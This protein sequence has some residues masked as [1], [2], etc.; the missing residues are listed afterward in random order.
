MLPASH[1]PSRTA[2]PLPTLAG[3][4]PWLAPLRA[5]VLK[6]RKTAHI[7]QEQ[8]FQ[9]IAEALDRRAQR[10]PLDRDDV[11][12]HLKARLGLRPHQPEL[13]HLRPPACLVG[14]DTKKVAYL[15]AKSGFLDDLASR[16]G[17]GPFISSELA[18][19]QHPKLVL[20]AL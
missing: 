14:D 6:E 9:R 15:H 13:D 12:H 17:D 5:P 8:L 2:W 19:G 10:K 16:A 18:A 7:G 4:R 1:T 11:L 20:A 3:T